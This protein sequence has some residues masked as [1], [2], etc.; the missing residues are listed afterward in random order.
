MTVNGSNTLAF[1][2]IN[3]LLGFEVG[4]LRTGKK[5]AYSSTGSR[6]AAVYVGDGERYRSGDKEDRC[7]AARKPSNQVIYDMALLIQMELVIAGFVMGLLS[8]RPTPLR[9][10]EC[11]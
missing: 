3:G 10:V 11:G 7:C 5:L 1:V 8:C 4:D 6:I 2:K 9:F